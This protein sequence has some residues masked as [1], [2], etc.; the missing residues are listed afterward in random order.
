MKNL[1][2]LM[3]AAFLFGAGANLA[4]GYPLNGLSNSESRGLEGGRFILMA[5][6]KTT[7]AQSETET[8]QKKAREM[9]NEYKGKL[10]ELEGKA[11]DLNEKAKAEARVG[12][13]ELQ[14]KMDAAEEKVKSI[15]SASGE[16]WAKLKAEVDSSLESVK[17]AYKKAAARFE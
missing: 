15:R 14:K 9:I 4:H 5:Q 11:K 13:E 2:I 1:G 7:P 8:Y 12:M 16:A 10:K 3:A 17:E 6:A